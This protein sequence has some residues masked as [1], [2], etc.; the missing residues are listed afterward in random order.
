MSD[1]KTIEDTY[2]QRGADYRRMFAGEEDYKVR[3]REDLARLCFAHTSTFNADPRISALQDGM[4]AVWLY[5]QKYADLSE[6]ELRDL[7]R[8]NPRSYD[9]P[10]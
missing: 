4:R 1:E 9:R 10:V 5:I 2:A 6:Q 7:A 3:I 8:K